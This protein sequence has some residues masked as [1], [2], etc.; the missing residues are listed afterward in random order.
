MDFPRT[1]M[2]SLMTSAAGAV[3][4]GLPDAYVLLDHRHTVVLANDYYLSALQ[5]TLDD[6]ID[7]SI[8][9]IN[10][11]GS[12]A[13]CE[14]RNQ[15]I[16][17]TLNRVQPNAPVTSSAF[18]YEM[19]I[20]NGADGAA[21]Q[22]RYWIIKASLLTLSASE[23]P[24]L[25]MRVDEATDEIVSVEKHRRERAQ[26]R[27]EAQLR[28]ILVREAQANYRESQDR[29][30]MALEFAHLGAWELDAATADFTC[31]DQCK[32]NLGIAASEMVSEQRFF[33]ELIDEVDR[34]RVME[35]M[36]DALR[37]QRPFEADY[38]RTW[39]NGDKHWLMIKG[40]G[41]Y[42]KDGALLTVVGFT[43]DI[44]ARKEYEIAQENSARE[45]REARQRSEQAANTMDHFVTAVSHELRSPLSAIVSWASLL[46]RSREPGH[47]SRGAEAIQRN[48]R[49]LT[50]MV[51]DLLDSGAIVSGKLSVV[52][53][54]VDLGSLAGNVLEDIR[55]VAEAKGLKVAAPDIQPCLVLGDESRLRQIVWNLLTNAV[56][57]TSEGVITLAV[58]RAGEKAILAVQDSGR[59]IAPEAAHAIFDRFAQV[60]QAASGRVGGLGL[61][62]WLVKTLVDMHEG[63]IEVQSQGVGMGATF[64]VTLPCVR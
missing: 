39:P 9:K 24:Y 13:Q 48:A 22:S 46:E 17:D 55:P 6:V 35:T 34:K 63:N 7:R 18:A 23:P 40:T 57:F 41:R 16:A 12:P 28:R 59:G 15:W 30:M 53:Q 38:R 36:E 20:G 33:H 31:S 29:F 21:L 32:V 10:Q 37:L 60:D 2:S 26:L 1:K 25:V 4:L 14:A 19:P 49:Q 52:R 43:L 58:Q 8:Y 62:L 44:T 61:G 11:F 27:S 47:V 45:E 56:K 3:F 51:D 54:A 42:G 64:K 50:H 5:C